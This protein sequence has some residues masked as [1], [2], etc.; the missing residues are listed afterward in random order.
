[1]VLRVVLP[2]IRDSLC[3]LDQRG[4]VA[5]APVGCG[6]GQPPARRAGLAAYL[7]GGLVS[8]MGPRLDQDG[9]GLGAR[10]PQVSLPASR[11]DRPGDR[12]GGLAWLIECSNSFRALGPW[13]LGPVI[14]AFPLPGP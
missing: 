12:T 13:G 2:S 5:M 7:L 14:S 10:P 8:R 4:L 6:L 11:E 9:T 1:M 3:L